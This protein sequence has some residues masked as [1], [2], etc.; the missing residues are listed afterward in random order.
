M[1]GGL[2]GEIKKLLEGSKAG[3]LGTLD[4]AGPLV[5]STGYLYEA[6]AGDY[7]SLFF[8]LSSLARHTEN[9][10]RDSRC[11]FLVEEG[12]PEKSVHERSRVSVLGTAARVG[13]AARK[14]S[15]EQRYRM[16][17]PK[18]A[19]FF[20]LPDFFFFEM[21]IKEVHWIGGFGKARRLP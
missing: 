12:A 8:F 5:T 11:S 21:N 1:A 2:P 9:L 16:A 13:D 14:A 7:G 17:F 20:K 6:G 19:P 10:N 4:S 18:S 15:L 3:A